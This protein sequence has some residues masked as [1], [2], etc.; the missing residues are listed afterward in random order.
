MNAAETLLEQRRIGTFSDTDTNGNSQLL[1]T[2]SSYYDRPVNNVYVLLA[3][4]EDTIKFGQAFVY[5]SSD[6]TLKSTLNTHGQQARVTSNTG[7]VI[8]HVETNATA[9]L[10]DVNGFD[11]EQA[12]DVQLTYYVYLESNLALV[13]STW[14]T[15]N[16]DFSNC[17]I[18]NSSTSYCFKFDTTSPSIYY[19]VTGGA[20][21][22]AF[23]MANAT[24]ELSN[25]AFPVG[26]YVILVVA[27]S[28]EVY[29]NTQDFIV[30][31]PPGLALNGLSGEIIDDIRE[32][33]VN[34][35]QTK[36]IELPLF[37]IPLII[38]SMISCKKLLFR[39]RILK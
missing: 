6:I 19:N 39:R 36:N 26:R 25:A 1:V 10:T 17:V 4:L 24:I 38:L 27:E 23:G 12:S 2:N 30:T 37:F 9:F 20:I 21:T 16:A 33:D 18:T 29:A 13:N 11:P 34:T 35:E 31:S 28:M 5:F 32:N 8:W 3:H 14:D 7:K 15:L 22:D